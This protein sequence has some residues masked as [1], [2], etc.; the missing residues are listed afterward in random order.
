MTFSCVILAVDRFLEMCAPKIAK[1]VFGGKRIYIWLVIP[2]IYTLYSGFHVPFL[3]NTKRY[4]YFTD[5][6][7]EIDGMSGNEAVIFCLQ[8][9]LQ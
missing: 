5:P 7:V 8:I 4:A 3:Y 2:V 1:V 6:F 9:T